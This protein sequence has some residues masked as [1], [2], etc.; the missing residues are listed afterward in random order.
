MAYHPQIYSISAPQI[1]KG[2]FDR[3]SLESSL[4]QKAACGKIRLVSKPEEWNKILWLLVNSFKDSDG[5]SLILGAKLGEIKKSLPIE[6][7]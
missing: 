5:N 7:R 4:L 1:V 6:F 2:L 3:Q